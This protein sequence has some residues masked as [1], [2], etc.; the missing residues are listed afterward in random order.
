VDDEQERRD[1]YDASLLLPLPRPDEGGGIA[2][3][4]EA[5]LEQTIETL[6]ADRSPR[7]AVIGLSREQRS[8]IRIVQLLRGSRRQ[9]VAP[10]FM[11]RLRA[12]LFASQF[13]KTVCGAVL[14]ALGTLA[15]GVTAGLGLQEPLN[16]EGGG[17]VCRSDGTW[18]TS[19]ACP[20]AQESRHLSTKG[21]GS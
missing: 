13:R 9:E 10:E 15:A 20:G 7:R 4:E 2:V 18:W 3:S 6:L 1:G 17:R 5:R 12:R 16:L 8:I 14:S 11:E 19:S 21:G